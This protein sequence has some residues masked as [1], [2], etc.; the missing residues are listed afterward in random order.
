MA[1]QT[2]HY[3]AVASE[4]QAI[5]GRTDDK[6]AQATTK[7]IIENFA[8]MFRRDNPEFKRDLFV[9]ACQPGANAQARTA[10]G[11]RKGAR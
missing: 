8:D 4:F 2:R 1:F 10:E 9:A 7:R 11:A 5:L 6:A 3:Q